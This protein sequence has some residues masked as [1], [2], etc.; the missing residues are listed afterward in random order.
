MVLD[1]PQLRLCL[2]RVQVISRRPARLLAALAIG[3]AGFVSA[4]FVLYIAAAAT[5]TAFR[6]ADVADA[7]LGT[8]HALAYA[9]LVW[10]LVPSL[11]VLFWVPLLA[12]RRLRANV[13]AAVIVAGLLGGVSGDWLLTRISTTNQCEVGYS[14]PYDFG[15]CE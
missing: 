9:S 6:A 5:Y 4:L 3:F 15:A 2:G 7:G 10:I 12:A 14:F 1:Q 13:L 8:R 11:A